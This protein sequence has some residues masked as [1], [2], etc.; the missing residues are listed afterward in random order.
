MEGAILVAFYVD[1]RG[2]DIRSF[3]GAG[4]ENEYSLVFVR[5]D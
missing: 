5:K 3:T 2:F 4:V 1:G